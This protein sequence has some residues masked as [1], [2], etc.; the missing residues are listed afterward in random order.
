[1]GTLTSLIKEGMDLLAIYAQ[2]RSV[3]EDDLDVVR[4]NA[5][6]TRKIS[7]VFR[8]AFVV[9]EKIELDTDAAENDD[10]DSDDD[11]LAGRPRR[12]ALD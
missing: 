2:E 6:K 11:G 12:K 10:S 5:V 3:D 1:M 8:A 9:A 7:G 4:E